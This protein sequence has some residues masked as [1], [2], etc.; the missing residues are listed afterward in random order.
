[1][2]FE[3]SEE[4]TILIQN[5]RR[6]LDTEV[7]PDLKQM[8]EGFLERD[9]MQGYLQS[10]AEFGLTRAP[11]PEQWGG[12]GLD[13][14]THLMVFEEVA[15]TSLDLAIPGFANAIATEM[16][17]QNGS[18]QLKRKYLPGLLS[19][20]L[21]ASLGVSE[22][23]VGSDPTAMKTR[24][25]LGDEGWC[26]NG[27]KTWITNGVYSDLFICTA[28]TGEDE[29]SHIVVDRHEHGY[30]V[31]NIEKIAL[32]RQST[33][34]VFLSDVVVPQENLLGKRGEGLTNSFRVF[35]IGRCHMAVWG[36]G[37]ARRAMDEAIRY[38]QERQQ[39]GKPIAAHQLIAD[40]IAT[41]ATHIDA[42]R[43][44]T[45]RA[46]DMVQKGLR[47]E[48]ECAMAKWFGT[49]MAVTA[50]RDALQIHGANGLTKDFLV[51]RLVREAVI[52]PMP[53]G[54]TEIQKLLIARCLTGI[55]AFR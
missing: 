22:P 18:E 30:E 46:I 29:F 6:F 37:I 49:E 47:A 54:T 41:M 35:D 40:K 14:L 11:H 53:D 4:Q 24:A 17:L 44:L 32:N 31:T 20:E 55:D 10:L 42:A 19:G 34:Q 43:L 33:A 9:R 5:L 2:N 3:V 51:E 26:I 50:T 27:E 15:Y 12:Y 13:W 8:G 16:I 45:Y 25:S 39:Y 38:S 28:K 36:I 52:N 21:F 48:K 1:M 23:D 7:E